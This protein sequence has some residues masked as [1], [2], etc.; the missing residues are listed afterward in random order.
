MSAMNENLF[1]AK[2]VIVFGLD[3][4]VALVAICWF[5]LGLWIDLYNLPA[6]H[7]ES[8][9]IYFKGLVCTGSLLFSILYVMLSGFLLLRAASDGSSESRLPARIFYGDNRR[10]RAKYSV[11]AL[12]IMMSP[13]FY[14]LM[15]RQ[16]ETRTARIAGGCAI[17]LIAFVGVALIIDLL[18]TTYPNVFRMPWSRESSFASS[19]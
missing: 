19:S 11:Y 12:S 8:A 18:M 7:P 17:T 1:R 4:I 14:F 6:H 9:L 16:N 13:G 10:L 5:R 2:T 3:V 15:W